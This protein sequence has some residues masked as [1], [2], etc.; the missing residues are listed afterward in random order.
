[1]REECRLRVL[2]NRVM[3]RVFGPERDDIT[4]ELRQLLNEEI[5]DLY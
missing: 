1:L 5:N 4:E 3:R 2:K